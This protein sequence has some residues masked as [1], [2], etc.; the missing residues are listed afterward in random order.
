MTA[1]LSLT[2]GLAGALPA[3]ADQA[4]TAAV[5]DGQVRLDRFE[6]TVSGGWG[7]PDR[8][9]AWATAVPTAVAV[10]G[11]TGHITLAAA[12]RGV[13]VVS[14]QAP[15]TDVDALTTLRVDSAPVGGP[16]WASVVG[17]RVG[18]SDYRAKLRFAPDHSVGLMLS[19]TVGVTESALVATSLA[20]DYKPGTPLQV[21][22]R[23]RG[24]SP[25]TLAAK[26]WV[27]GAREPSSW[28]LRATDSTAG[29]Q[30]AGS[31]AVVGYRSSGSTATQGLTVDDVDVRTPVTTLASSTSPSTFT[32]SSN[33]ADSSFR[34]RWDSSAYVAC[35][36]PVTA[37]ALTGGSHVLAVRATDADG[38]AA[39]VVTRSWS[40][41]VTAPTASFTRGPGAGSSTTS[42]SARFGLASS[43]PGSYSC[44]LDAGA[45]AR[46]WSTVSYDGLAVGG[47]TLSVRAS[48]AAGNVSAVV[49]R[50]WSITAV[51]SR[52]TPS[53]TASAAPTPTPT[54]S[55]TATA[56]PAPAPTTV[57]TQ[58]AA[59]TPTATP[60]PTATST[61]TPQPSATPT[62]T[63][64][65]MPQRTATPTPTATP[66]PV[67]VSGSQPGPGNTGVPAGTALTRYDGDLTITTPGTVIDGLDIHGFVTIK[68]NN[69]TIRRSIVRGGVAAITSGNRSLITSTYPGALIEDTELAP[70]FPSVRIDGL[71]GYGFTARRLN[72][73]DAVDNTLIWGDNTVLQSSWLHDNRHY[74]VDPNQGGG[75]SH[76]DSIQVQGGTNIRIEGNT[77]TGAYGAAIQVTQDYTLTTSLTIAGNWLG[78]GGCSVNVAEKGKGPL[79][80]LVM[81]SNKFFRTS[82][83]NCP[84]IIPTTTTI[85][86]TNNTYADNGATISL[87]RN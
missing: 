40:T 6:R 26:V 38:F 58:T 87:I 4:P 60:L 5:T 63:P 30:A 36:S 84:A 28:T 43:E 57:P 34:C 24:A 45:W 39:P 51:A 44:R 3:V 64:T 69:V 21:R 79:Q 15:S 67:Q 12:G 13:D 54:P 2:A 11:G 50:S 81:A 70:E 16:T 77:T 72:I 55:P 33:T 31:T 61:A 62:A 7:T 9:G 80:S 49:S 86:N 52:P 48:D 83:F 27:R 41:D 18:T 22:I 20:L 8:G 68:A 53:S 19:R 85:T 1:L 10:R 59:P 82:Q 35:S 71:K 46:C 17:R 37:P 23:V 75:V 78:N 73:H 42:T 56:A 47:H 29:L 65:A 74:A 66:A 25:S 14:P 76:D 32:I